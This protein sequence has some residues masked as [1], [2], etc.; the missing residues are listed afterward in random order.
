MSYRRQETEWPAGWLF[1][2]LAEHFHGAEVFKDIDSIEFGDDFVEVITTA[3]QSCD[4]LLA[5]IGDRWL[6]M[7]DDEGRRRIDNPDDFVRIEIQAALDRNVRVVPILIYGARMPQAQD[8]PP[9][10]A[11]LVRRHALELSV[12]RFD[13]DVSRLLRVLDKT[14]AEARTRPG[15]LPEQTRTP[16]ETPTPPQTQTPPET[17]TSPPTRP[18]THDTRPQ[19]QG[20]RPQT[21]ETR[22]QT[23]ETRPQTQETRPQTQETPR[24]E[25]PGQLAAK[26]EPRR[27]PPVVIAAAAV[28]I[29]LVLGTAI[30]WWPRLTT[31]TGGT[32][33]TATTSPPAS[34][35]ASAGKSPYSSAS[36]TASRPVLVW[37][38]V[39]SPAARV[40]GAAAAAYKGQIWV[41]GGMGTTV[42]VYDP[43][44]RQWQDGPPLPADLGYGAL[45]SDGQKLYYMGGIN[46]TVWGVPTVY[47]LDSPGG[48]WEQGPPLPDARY[49]GAAVWDGHR[50]M[51]AGGT[52][53]HTPRRAASEIWAL[54]S[55]R[56]GLVANLPSPREKLAAASDGNGIVWFAGGADVSARTVSGEVDQ[57]QGSTVEKSGSLSKPVQGLTAVWNSTS[58]ACVIGGST[59]LPNDNARPTA[60]V[61]CRA[62]AWPD[63]PQPTGLATSATLADTAYVLAGSAMFALRFTS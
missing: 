51:F 57:L 58:G 42:R 14:L 16:P 5:L 43:A 32:A 13:D 15:L 62:S 19:T 27:P 12:S 1:D 26:G 3:V 9:S 52:Q 48:R 63:I 54:T 28:A 25:T 59:T 36:P 24:Q 45:A 11:G 34:G 56:W 41:V 18:Q 29:L 30:W 7:T 35:S 22:P 60:T 4:V 2:R 39:G 38:S 55:G 33:N 46:G 47:V 50:L 53:G 31:G 40:S 10:L 21:Q 17:D 44:S 6:T 61:T 8:L 23:Q 37:Q 20:T 49:S